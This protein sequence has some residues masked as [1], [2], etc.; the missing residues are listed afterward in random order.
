[1]GSSLQKE[2]NENKHKRIIMNKYEQFIQQEIQSVLKPNDSVEAL[3]FLYNKSLL[4]MVMFGII[5]FAGDGYFFAVATQQQLLLIETEMGFSALKTVNKK[6][7][8]VPYDQIEA[9]KIG[10]FFNQKTIML[11][12]KTGKAMRFRLN[13]LASFVPGQKRFINK[14]QSLYQLSQKVVH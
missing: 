3:G 14:L 1:L 13:V 2:I 7:T 11:K 8:Q 10:G 9:I 5:S 4:G 12:L 6:L